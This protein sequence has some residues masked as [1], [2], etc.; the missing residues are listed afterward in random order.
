MISTNSKYFSVYPLRSREWGVNRFATGQVFEE[1]KKAPLEGGGIADASIVPPPTGTYDY[2][3]GKF[4]EKEETR[5]VSVINPRSQMLF[6]T[7]TPKMVNEDDYEFP[8]STIGENYYGRLDSPWALFDGAA[9]AGGLTAV[10]LTKIYDGNST[11]G[12]LPNAAGF[13]RC[14]RSDTDGDLVLTFSKKVTKVEVV[15]H[16]WNAKS[17]N[18]P[19]SEDVRHKM[20]AFWE[21]LRSKNLIPYEKY[22]RLMRNT[23]LQIME[24]DGITARRL[25]ETH[26][27]III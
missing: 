12:A 15:C 11:G 6:I 5:W 18:Y 22:R 17:D 9:S 27:E 19:L 10:T 13:I 8:N 14:G 21:M 4:M 7:F 20:S 3:I 2:M 23:P 1:L 26:H 24:A 16:D 25:T